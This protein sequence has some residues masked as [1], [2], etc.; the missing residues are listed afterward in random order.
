MAAELP[1]LPAAGERAQEE[2][3]HHAATQFADT[4]R[5]NAEGTAGRAQ[6]TAGAASTSYDTE[7]IRSLSAQQKELRVLAE[8][9]GCWRERECLRRRRRLILKRLR[10]AVRAKRERCCLARVAAI[11]ALR[12]N[13]RRFYAT[14]RHF[15]RGGRRNRAAA[16]LLDPDTGQYITDLGTDAARFGAFYRSLF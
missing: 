3:V 12:H 10:R 16:R 11:E 9:C 5:R 13:T 2:E 1:Q 14:L 4:L 6:R 7:E 8:A 15:H